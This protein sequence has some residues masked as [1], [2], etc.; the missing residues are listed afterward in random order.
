MTCPEM[1]PQDYRAVGCYSSP[2]AVCACDIPVV[3]LGDV[4][5]VQQSTVSHTASASSER[6]DVH[7]HSI[8]DHICMT[9]LNSTCRHPIVHNERVN[10]AGRVDERTYET[11]RYI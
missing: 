8:D 1:R 4:V 11:P 7:A 10:W 9:V 3:F 5:E 2:D 6:R